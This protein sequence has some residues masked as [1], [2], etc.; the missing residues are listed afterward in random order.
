[1]NQLSQEFELVLLDAPPAL[2]HPDALILSR[3]CKGIVLVT[4]IAKN[5]QLDIRQAISA[6]G[7]SGAPIIGV[8]ANRA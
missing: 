3:A 2:E 1:M 8:V 5:R 4:V 6:L 7:R